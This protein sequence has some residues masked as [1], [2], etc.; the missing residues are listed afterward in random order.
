MHE[1][2]FLKLSDFDFDFP[3]ELVAQTPAA[4]RDSS[5]L[6]V[7]AADGAISHHQFS[8]LPAVLPAGS[9]LVLN[10]TS[11]LQS[12]LHGFLKTGARIEIFLLEPLPAQEPSVIWRALAKPLK[13]LKVGSEILFAPVGT[14]ASVVRDP[15]APVTGQILAIEE[16]AADGEVPA[17]QIT[18]SPGRG[19]DGFD[20]HRWL[21]EAGETP[22]PPY[23]HRKAGDK[24]TATTDRGRY[25]TVYAA[26]KGSVA[27]PTAGLHFTTGLLGR[28]RN[29]GHGTVPVTLH[30]GGGTF[31][32]VRQEDV[33]LHQM[34]HEKF[35]I[36][37]ESL[38][39]IIEAKKS[40]RPIICVGTTAF[41]CVEGLFSMAAESGVD[42][43]SL[44]GQW[45][46]TNL[47][48]YPRNRHD[49]FQPRVAD[50]LVTNFHQPKSTLFM[51]VSALV[52][53]DEAHRMYRE[54]IDLRYRLFSY[55]DGSLLLFR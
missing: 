22:L 4:E 45:H 44:A 26:S 40:G 2:N 54:A 50:G 19:T 1:E 31:L 38:A 48:I 51:L 49:R 33:A 43:A 53:L 55:G 18:F 34:H 20:F 21:E 8:D 14:S 37:R 16:P 13:K 5:R 28:L 32:P 6:L 36:P 9:V 24:E 41:R 11:V 10:D 35:L 30:V 27:A 17:V 42:P 23:I 7:H 29:L 39:G 47:F 25:E 46:A 12:R 52:G 15:R 3:A